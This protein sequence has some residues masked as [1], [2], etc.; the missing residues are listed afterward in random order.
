MFWLLFRGVSQK[1]RIPPVWR[2]LK[3]MAQLKQMCFALPVFLDFRLGC[4][5][6]FWLPGAPSCRGSWLQLGISLRQGTGKWVSIPSDVHPNFIYGSISGFVS[7]ASA[8][9]L[10]LWNSCS[11][12]LKGFWPLHLGL[13]GNITFIRHYHHFGICSS[14]F[15]S[16]LR[17]CSRVLEAS[18]LVKVIVNGYCRFTLLLS[19][20][21]ICAGSQIWKRVT[22]T[23]D[24]K[25]VSET[26]W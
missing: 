11:L 8:S 19:Q 13:S 5:P 4:V 12:Q 15:N 1:P 14:L 18:D 6:V 17:D 25:A 26:Y 3:E 16:E 22:T 24:R 20:E 10:Y 21:G 7:I 9:F 23:R 2:M